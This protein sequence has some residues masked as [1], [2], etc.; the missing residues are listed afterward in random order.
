M[1]A[2]IITLKLHLPTYKSMQP[3]SVC[4]NEVNLS[5]S[6]ASHYNHYFYHYVS[7]GTWQTS[8]SA[9]SCAVQEQNSLTRKSSLAYLCWRGFELPLVFPSL[10][11][12]TE[13]ASFQ[14]V[15]TWELQSPP[16]SARCNQH[17]RS[18][19]GEGCPTSGAICKIPFHTVTYQWGLVGAADL[20]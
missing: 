2:D 8:S 1:A 16:V 20:C 15:H 14:H 12:V 9:I 4:G 10:L 6:S 19:L 13:P 3:Q 5:F 7:S 18:C 11:K 17:C